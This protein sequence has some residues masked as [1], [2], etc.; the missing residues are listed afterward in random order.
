MI[1]VANIGLFVDYYS[2]QREGNKIYANTITKTLKINNTPKSF[3]ISELSKPSKA[4]LE[5]LIMISSKGIITGKLKTGISK[6]LP[7]ALEEIADNMVKVAAKPM[8]PIIVT[9]KNKLRD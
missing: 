2:F 4:R 8:Q 9:N 7:P 1:D 3:S 5:A 6:L